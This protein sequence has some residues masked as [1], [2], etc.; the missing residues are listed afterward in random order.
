MVFCFTR[1]STLQTAEALADW[2]QKCDPSERCWDAPTRVPF[3]PDP[4]L[5]G[6]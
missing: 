4:A 3:V 5:H 2:W 1:K 6:V